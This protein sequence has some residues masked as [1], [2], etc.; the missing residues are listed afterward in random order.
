MRPG[1]LPALTLLL[2]VFA[3]GCSLVSQ[4][5]ATPIIRGGWA[6]P[7][8]APLPPGAVAVPIDV[9]PIQDLPA[10]AVIGCPAALLGPVTPEY[11]PGRTPPVTYRVADERVNVRWPVGFS[12]RLAP[13]LEIV[14]PDG[15]VIARGGE[16]TEGLGGGYTGGD[17]FNVCIGDW[18]RRVGAPG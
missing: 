4:P 5:P 11:Q 16:V 1:P 2:A 9:S 12:A 6:W 10:D 13:N 3:T 17:A 14:A 8:P 7:V 18:P 15:K